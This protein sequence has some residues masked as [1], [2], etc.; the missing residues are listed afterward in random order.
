MKLTLN[1][2]NKYYFQNQARST[3]QLSRYVREGKIYPAPIKVGR[4]YEVEPNAIF[5]TKE[6]IQNPRLMAEKIHEQTKR[7]KY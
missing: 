6:L 2:W 7:R 1:E 4:A 3:K 5:L